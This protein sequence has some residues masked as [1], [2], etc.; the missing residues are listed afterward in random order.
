MIGTPE[1]V[2]AGLNK[3]ID[4]GLTHSILDFIGLDEK[5]LELFNSKAIKNL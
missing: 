3:Y 4:L 2:M 5:T 1:N